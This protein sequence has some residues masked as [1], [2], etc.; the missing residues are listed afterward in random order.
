MKKT[1]K[2]KFT[3]KNPQ[4]MIGGQTNITY[5]SSWELS[6]CL[7]LDSHPSVEAWGSECLQIPYKHPIRGN[8]TIYVPD[9]LAVYV[10]K[11]GNKHVEII[12]VKPIAETPGFS[13]KNKS[14]RQMVI[15][16]AT[17]VKQVINAS[18]WS[19]C[20]HYAKNRGWSFRVITEKNLFHDPKNPRNKK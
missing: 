19:A 10:D 8:W 11:D 5:R 7:M 3:P 15:S 17:K 20:Q 4:K 18:K 12:E 6:V 13:K 2:G 16:D 14:G 1:D 9:F